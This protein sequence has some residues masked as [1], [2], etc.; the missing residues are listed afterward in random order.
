MNNIYIWHPSFIAG[1]AVAAHALHKHGAQV[2]H[3]YML[4]AAS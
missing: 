3:V 4:A 2:Q 1:A